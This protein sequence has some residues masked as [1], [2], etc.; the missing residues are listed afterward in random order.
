MLPSFPLKTVILGNM[1][2]SSKAIICQVL[3]EDISFTFILALVLLKSIL[4]I[5]PLIY[6]LSS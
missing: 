2:F 4:F 1:Y 3:K 6:N 5:V